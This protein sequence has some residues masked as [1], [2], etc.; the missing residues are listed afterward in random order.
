MK[1]NTDSNHT[2]QAP[3]DMDRL[4]QLAKL[5]VP[6]SQRERLERELGD[7][8]AFLSPLHQIDAGL[9]ETD[10]EAIHNVFRE[11]IVTPSFSREEVLEGVPDA[12]GEFFHVPGRAGQ[13]EG[14]KS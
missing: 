8:L 10:P 12:R 4:A 1:Q 7:I 6:P 11:D 5:S 2:K 3:V 9:P 13:G 14:D